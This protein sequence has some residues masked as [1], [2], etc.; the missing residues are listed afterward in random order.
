MQTKYIIALTAAS[1]VV[2]GAAGG[3]IFANKKAQLKWQAY[4][5]EQITSVK[6][7]Y[8]MVHDP[9]DYDTPEEADEANRERVSEYL[10]RLDEL[11][12][13]ADPEGR[14]SPEDAAKAAPEEAVA[15]AEP[16][17]SSVNFDK[18]Y[19]YPVSSDEFFQDHNDYPKITLQWYE[20]DEI[21][22]DDRDEVLSDY[23]SLVGNCVPKFFGFDKTQPDAVYV[24]NHSKEAAYEVLRNVGSYQE[25]VCGVPFVK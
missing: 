12:Y 1:G 13:L 14:T 6:K 17:A 19:P 3:Y 25:I 4:A 18:D 7:H 5:E 24:I 16:P 10:A 23:N 11:E 8:G 21:L 9:N 2:A 15:S 20:D 22:A